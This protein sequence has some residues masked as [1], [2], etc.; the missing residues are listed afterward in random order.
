MPHV[1]FKK[2]DEQV[3]DPSQYILCS[4]EMGSGLH[5]RSKWHAIIYHAL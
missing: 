1:V 4:L 3:L 5:S 2:H